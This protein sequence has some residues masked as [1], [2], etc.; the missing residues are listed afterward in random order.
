MT[1]NLTTLGYRP[2]AKAQCSMSGWPGRR[3]RPDDFL[4][5]DYEIGK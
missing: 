3:Q 5:I 4:T 1:L 2:V